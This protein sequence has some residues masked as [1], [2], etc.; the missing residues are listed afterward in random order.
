MTV[1]AMYL[2]RIFEIT[3]ISAWKVFFS[4]VPLYRELKQHQEERLAQNRTHNPDVETIAPRVLNKLTMCFYP[5]MHM[6]YGV[7]E[8]TGE[9]KVVSVIL[10]VFFIVESKSVGILESHEV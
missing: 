7:S 6:G 4:A 2:M 8:I 3:I 1:L 9:N 5:G 10:V